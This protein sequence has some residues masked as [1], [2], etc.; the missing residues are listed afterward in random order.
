MGCACFACFIGI[1]VL[2]RVSRPELT[3]PAIKIQLLGFSNSTPGKLI[4]QV[5]VTNSSRRVVRLEK[6]IG[7]E[8]GVGESFASV[9]LMDGVLGGNTPR[10]EPRRSDTFRIEFP[11]QPPSGPVRLRFSVNYDGPKEAMY[12]F[13]LKHGWL[14][15]MP[16]GWRPPTVTTYI[17][18]SNWAI[19][20]NGGMPF[21]A[22]KPSFQPLEII[23][24]RPILE[25]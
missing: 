22:P 3:A 6:D 5:Q 21:A 9:G 15:R 19:H 25:R 20:T 11:T 23:E 13:F 2:A 14:D 8:F 7:I 4:A 24:P 18:K 1:I 17:F 12:H 16:R 10:L